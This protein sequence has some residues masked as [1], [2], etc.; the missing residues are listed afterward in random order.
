MH[1]KYNKMIQP[2]MYLETDGQNDRHMNEIKKQLTAFTAHGLFLLSGRV[3]L[4]KRL[5]SVRECE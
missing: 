3:A 2:Q 4:G 1:I 5:P